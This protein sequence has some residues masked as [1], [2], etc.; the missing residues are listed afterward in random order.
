M[1][2]RL[3]D[4]TPK[5]RKEHKCM[6][7][8]ITVNVGEVYSKEAYVYE[9]KV[10]SWITCADCALIQNDVYYWCADPDFGVGPEEFLEWAIYNR[11]IPEATAYL[12]RLGYDYPED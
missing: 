8:Y 6:T 7:C 2:Q 1:P 10:Y 3:S 12:E 11:D 5:A 9:G 4:S